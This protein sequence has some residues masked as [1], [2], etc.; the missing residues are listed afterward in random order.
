MGCVGAYVL[1]EIDETEGGDP[2]GASKGF[3]AHLLS[4]GGGG[5]KKKKLKIELP[6]NIK[7]K[8][9]FLANVREV[10]L[11]PSKEHE[12]RMNTGVRDKKRQ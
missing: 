3:L 5:S 8:G 2:D 1:S 10:Y 7:E 9:S 11:P 6:K 4:S 12:R